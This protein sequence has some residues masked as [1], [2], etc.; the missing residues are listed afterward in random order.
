MV[1]LLVM[2]SNFDDVSRFSAVKVRVMHRV[3]CLRLIEKSNFSSNQ[4]ETCYTLAVRF[5]LL[6]L[7]LFQFHTFITFSISEYACEQYF[8]KEKYGKSLIQIETK[9]CVYQVHYKA[10]S[11]IAYENVVKNYENEVN[12]KSRLFLFVEA[13]EEKKS[14]HHR[15]YLALIFPY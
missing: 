15:V 11:V 8:L 5:N 14:Y 3:Q 13:K 6:F 12:E 9:K 4:H 10:H 7:F 2:I 1:T